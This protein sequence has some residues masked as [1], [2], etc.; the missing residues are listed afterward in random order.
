MVICTTRI[1][2]HDELANVKRKIKSNKCKMTE[3]SYSLS[4]SSG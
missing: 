2:L 3:T 1:I 4:Q